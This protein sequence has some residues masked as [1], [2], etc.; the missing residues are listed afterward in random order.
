MSLFFYGVVILGVVLGGL[1]L[2]VIFSLLAMAQR[3]DEYLDQLELEQYR[4]REYAPPLTKRGKSE[5]IRVSATPDLSHG[6]AI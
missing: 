4:V 2:L 5:N 3:S 1:V 6:G